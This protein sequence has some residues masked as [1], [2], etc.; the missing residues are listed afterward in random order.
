[1]KVSKR[2]I[3]EV[4]NK[5]EYLLE[6]MEDVGADEANTSCNT[7]GM[8][9][10]ISFGNNGYLDLNNLEDVIDTEEDY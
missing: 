5:L 10:F 6:M 9:K 1:M 4:I 2:E 7:Y 3:E 8:Y